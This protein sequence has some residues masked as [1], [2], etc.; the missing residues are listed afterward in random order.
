VSAS[1]VT[2]GT[3][4]QCSTVGGHRNFGG[5]CCRLLQGAVRVPETGSIFSPPLVDPSN[6]LPCNMTDHILNPFTPEVVAWLP[7]VVAWLPESWVL[8]QDM[9]PRMTM[10]ARTSSNLPNPTDPPSNRED[11]DSM[12]LQNVGIH[13]QYCYWC[14]IPGPQY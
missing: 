1:T 13:L 4:T 11:G 5:T 8:L 12:L 7:E 9:E 10:L 2:V 6:H 14:H 3:V